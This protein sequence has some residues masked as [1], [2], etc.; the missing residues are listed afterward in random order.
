METQNSRKILAQAVHRQ[1]EVIGYTLIFVII[2]GIICIAL[3][4]LTWLLSW[5]VCWL[6]V[7][8]LIWLI[9][10]VWLFIIKWQ[11]NFLINHYEQNYQSSGW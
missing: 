4:I 6:D 7:S 5:A 10:L 11:S 8:L 1:R 9:S 2:S 3:A